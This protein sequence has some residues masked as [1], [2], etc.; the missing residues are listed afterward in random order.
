MRRQLAMEGGAHGI[1][2]NAISPAL[3]ETS[4]T[5]VPLENIPGFREEAMNKSMSKRLGRP[6]D[7]GW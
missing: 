7:I 6:E 5:R 1:R 2:V 4:A 3:I